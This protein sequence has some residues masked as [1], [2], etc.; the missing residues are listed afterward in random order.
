LPRHEKKLQVTFHA[1]QKEYYC[2]PATAQM[3]LG[4]L[5]VKKL[6]QDDLWADIQNHSGG[7][8]PA[9]AP[10][11]P[12][13]F[14]T[15]VCYWCDGWEC[16]DTTPEALT[17]TVN[18]H[19]ARAARLNYVQTFNDGMDALVD[20]ISAIAPVPAAATILGVNHWV[21]VRGFRLNDEQ[22]PFAVNGVYILDPLERNAKVRMRLI[23]LEVWQE[24]F[25]SM[26]CGPHTNQR[27]IVVGV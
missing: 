24:L 15:Q 25:A 6:S 26:D 19:R 5:K 9:D 11:S 17:A 27:P 4:W 8:R 18:V 7:V 20:S 14:E 16:W 2:G 22:G 12:S 13:E 1:Q 10:S 3:I 21:V 23:A